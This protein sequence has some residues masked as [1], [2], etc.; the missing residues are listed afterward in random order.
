ME[1]TNHLLTG[2]ILQ[3]RVAMLNFPRREFCDQNSFKRLGRRD[4]IQHDIS[5][6][7]VKDVIWIHYWDILL[8]LTLP[9]TNIAP[10]NGWLECYFPIGKAYFQGLC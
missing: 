4:P 9:E 1:V 2:M 8:V 6:S 10:K 7:E 3:V 5:P